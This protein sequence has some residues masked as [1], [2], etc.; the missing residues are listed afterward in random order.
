MKA[1][2]FFIIMEARLIGKDYY[3]WTDDSESIIRVEYRGEIT[4]PVLPRLPRGR[5]YSPI[6]AVCK[7]ITGKSYPIRDWLMAAK[8]MQLNLNFAKS[9]ARAQD[10][11][12]FELSSRE[13]QHRRKLHRIVRLTPIRIF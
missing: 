1:E 12:M 6:T 7:L 3:W 5:S 13:K 4:D 11:N 10:N 9:L 2:E 8:E